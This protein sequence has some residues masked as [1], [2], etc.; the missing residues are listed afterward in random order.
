MLLASGIYPLAFAVAKT[1]I[2]SLVGCARQL[3]G[4]DLP[5]VCRPYHADLHLGEHLAMK[6]VFPRVDSV[7]DW[8]A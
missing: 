4:V 7:A 8:R 2:E 3:V 1:C 6:S 5:S